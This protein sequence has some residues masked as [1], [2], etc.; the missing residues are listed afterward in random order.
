MQAVCMKVV[1]SSSVTCPKFGGA[2]TL[3]L[4]KQQYFVVD[5]ACQSTKSQNMLEM[6][7]GHGNLGPSWLHL[8][9]HETN[10]N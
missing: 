5:T 8:W 7:G 6:F 2:N 9:F 10:E 4:S 3:T 1:T